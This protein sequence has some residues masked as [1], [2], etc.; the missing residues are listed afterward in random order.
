MK[1]VVK[2]KTKHSEQV[3]REDFDDLTLAY[4]FFNNKTKDYG[5]LKVKLY[6]NGELYAEWEDN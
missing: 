6:K 5:T 3:M 1:L 2:W 4:Q